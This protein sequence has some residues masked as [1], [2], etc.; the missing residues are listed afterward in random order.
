M[1]DASVPLSEPPRY[2]EEY[3]TQYSVLKQKAAH[4]LRGS[5]SA[6]RHYLH[7]LFPIVTW[8][9]KYN[10]TWF[11]SDVIA[12]LTVGM[13]VIPQALAYAKLATLPVQ[14]G[15]YTS[16]TGVL[17]YCFFATSKDV[18]IG[19]TAVVSQLT[20]QLIAS[21]ASSG[22]FDPVM[23]AIALA[24]LTGVF[25]LI[26]G[27][28][29]LG[30][31]VDFIPAPVIAGFTSGAGITIIIGQLAGLLGIA[32]INT[33]DN[34]YLVLGN[35]LKNLGD[36]KLD[37]AFGFASLAFLLFFKFG[38][39]ALTDRGHR[40]ARWVGISRNALVVI[41]FTAISYGVNHNLAK[42]RF[43]IVG[44][45][46][47]GFGPL[48]V[49]DARHI[50]GAVPASITVL[51][52]SILEHV[53][54]VKSYGRLNGYRPDANQELV[55]LGATNLLGSF[56]GTFPA[57]GSFSRSAIKSQSGVR[58]PLASLF[59]AVIVVLALY[60][61]TPLFKYIPSA[62]LSAIIV[63]AISDL[64]SRPALVK[65]L[66]D[67][68]LL[69]L[70]A[71]VLALGFTFFFSIEIAIYVS[72]AYSVV[73]LLYRLARPHYAVLGRVDQTG[74]WVSTKDQF[75]G[76]IATPPPPGVLV[77]KLE[78]SLTYPNAN[79]FSE[80]IKDV[81]ISTTEFGGVV[82]PPD[83]KLWCD[84]TDD[85][86][87]S[88]RKKNN[89]AVQVHSL[90]KVG[91]DVTIASLPEVAKTA[92]SKLHRLCAI[93]FDFSAV[94]GIDSTGVQMLTDLRRDVDAYAGQRVEFHFAHV[95]PRFERILSYFLR[96]TRTD[97]DVTPIVPPSLHEPQ[98]SSQRANDSSA[99]VRQA[100]ETDSINQLPGQRPP[101]ASSTHSVEEHAGGGG[102]NDRDDGRP[103]RPASINVREYF[104]ATVD[105]AVKVTLAGRDVEAAWTA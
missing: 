79:Y 5:G 102:D 60:V 48:Q 50:R 40:W 88:A 25:Q 90:Q 36:A 44:D 52:V 19:A 67:I 15:L 33:N 105:D 38:C 28:L 81:V 24:F 89:N 26:I 68:Q 43:K 80:H 47:K 104:H 103:V 1:A 29:R 10:R 13:V 101:D 45:V 41:L 54:V 37:A 42:A 76:R 30:I 12:G 31:V 93:V 23:F 22:E 7:S 46:P 27:L 14:Y 84:D 91:S 66:W 94:N 62:T 72:V 17:L 95:R 99:S 92:D 61:L 64:I 20:G 74:L 71:F 85:K 77:V 56:L 97:H 51:I 21:H 82:L 3:P 57:T 6:A 39:R 8:L 58:T 2:P 55:A 32:G 16:F 70:V 9:P 96:I 69:D 87:K 100:Q 49:P 35:T 59:T 11:F 65:Q 75:L 4:R 53:A 98:Y 86:I 78:E 73:V 63:S 34:S 83:Q 18:T